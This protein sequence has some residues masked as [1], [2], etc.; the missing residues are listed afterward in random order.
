MNLFYPKNGI[1]EEKLISS[2]WPYELLDYIEECRKAGRDINPQLLALSI[3][4]KDDDNPILILVHLKK[5]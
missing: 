2:I 3:I 4:I 1:F 5:K